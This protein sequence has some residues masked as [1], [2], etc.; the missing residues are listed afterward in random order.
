[1]KLC[2]VWTSKTSLIADAVKPSQCVTVGSG[3][4]VSALHS[5]TLMVTK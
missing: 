3:E 2:Q 5:N 4:E 1:M